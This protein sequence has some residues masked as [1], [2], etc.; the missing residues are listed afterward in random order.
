MPSDTDYLNF[1]LEQ[2]S[3]LDE[4][5]CR[6]MMGEYLL[7]HRGKLFGGIYDNR[8]LVKSVPSAKKM[9]P[10]AVTELPYEGGSKMILVDNP[11]DPE[12]LCRLVQAMYEELPS[13]KKKCVLTE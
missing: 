4:I 7:Y 2:L 5:T 11:D 8:F 10:D 6:S 12:F 1:I 3:G 9:M 13:R